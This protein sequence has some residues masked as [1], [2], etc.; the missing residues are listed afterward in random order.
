MSRIAE[1]FAQVL[2]L[3]VV[4]LTTWGALRLC[5]ADDRVAL[6]ACAARRKKPKPARRPVTFGT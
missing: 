6:A 4:V 5:S 1:W 3:Y 2:V